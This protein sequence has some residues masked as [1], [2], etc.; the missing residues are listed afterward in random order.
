MDPFT[1]I[2]M[3]Q[4]PLTRWWSKLCCHISQHTL[5]TQRVLIVTDLQP[6]GL[7]I[8]PGHRLP[9]YWV[10]TRSKL[11]LPEVAPKA[12]TSLFEGSPWLVGISATTLLR[13]SQ[14]IPLSSTHVVP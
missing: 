7:W 6:T 3:Q 12:I 2:T 13:R 10:V 9:N 11:R 8:E 1:L 4:R 14:N 5:A